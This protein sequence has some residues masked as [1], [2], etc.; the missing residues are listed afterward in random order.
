[1]ASLRESSVEGESQVV[2]DNQKSGSW[3]TDRCGCI[4]T[5]RSMM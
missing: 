2:G 1:M 5:M 3:F 4:Y